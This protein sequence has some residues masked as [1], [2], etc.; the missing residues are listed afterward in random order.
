MIE[1]HVCDHINAPPLLG[2]VNMSSITNCHYWL[3]WKHMMNIL[4]QLWRYQIGSIEY[5]GI[6]LNISIGWNPNMDIF[7][8]SSKCAS[9][10]GFKYF[11]YEPLNINNIHPR[12]HLSW[13]LRKQLRRH[14][15]GHLSRYLGEQRW[16]SLKMVALHLIFGDRFNQLWCRIPRRSS[17][18]LISSFHFL[19]AADLV[20]Y[21]LEGAEPKRNAAAAARCQ[22]KGRER[23]KHL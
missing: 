22:F 14:L 4:D 5:S 1:G 20:L 16:A 2:G 11:L 19:P 6:S 12:R 21:D 18:T 9:I 23:T 10:N 15:R 17:K 8:G 7:W 3:L 13:H